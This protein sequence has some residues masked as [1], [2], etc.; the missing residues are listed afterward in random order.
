[1][2]RTLFGL[3]VSAI[4]L[5]GCASTQ[6]VAVNPI[7]GANGPARNDIGRAISQ[8]SFFTGPAEVGEHQMAAGPDG[9]VWFSDTRAEKIGYITPGGAVTEFALP[10]GNAVATGIAAG[11]DGNI[12]YTDGPDGLIGRMTLS[13]TVTTFSLRS[14]TRPVDIT[15]APDG[16]LWFTAQTPSTGAWWLGRMTTSGS[17]TFFAVPDPDASLNGITVG[18]DGNIWFAN[19]G[20][21]SIGRITPAGVMTEFK[22]PNGAIPNRITP[23]SDGAVYS[24]IR[25]GS[26]GLL[27]TNMKG[28]VTVILDPNNSHPFE[29]ISEG[30]RHCIWGSRVCDHGSGQC[31]DLFNDYRHTFSE[32]PFTSPIS[33]LAGLVAGPDGNMWFQVDDDSAHAQHDGLGKHDSY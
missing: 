23:A 8:F 15:G 5:A 20:S 17:A 2:Q 28:V 18:I 22:T 3:A 13:G 10:S 32:H 21:A 31:F 27:R 24:A 4:V 19:A 6:P 14:G 30:P 33:G 9:N 16:D 11:P 1:M 29:V 7:A 26:G 25:G 12:W